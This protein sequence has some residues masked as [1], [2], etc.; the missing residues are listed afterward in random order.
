MH[1]LEATT[2]VAPTNASWSRSTIKLVS[3]LE[4]RAQLD[5]ARSA[6]RRVLVGI[7]AATRDQ[8]KRR[9]L[10]GVP[11]KIRAAVGRTGSEGRMIKGIEH[12]CLQTEPKPFSD[13]KML[14]D[15]DVVVG[16]MGPVDPHPLAERARRSIRRNVG[17]VGATCWE[18]ILGIN[19]RDVS[20]SRDRI[21]T[22]GAL[23]L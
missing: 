21:L 2:F 22:N 17:W 10:N 16:V 1:S 4:V 7:Q 8:P 12:L 15:G 23:Q 20:R 3:E 19:E 13:W 14:R 11:A 6:V 18:K 5:L 9:A